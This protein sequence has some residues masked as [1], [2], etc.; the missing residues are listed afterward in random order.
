MVTASGPVVV[1]TPVR[2][3]VTVVKIPFELVVNVEVNVPD[4]VKVRK[5]VVWKRVVALDVRKETVGPLERLA[6]I[7]HF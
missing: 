3:D 5:E 4:V 6:H 7:I 1:A 2:V